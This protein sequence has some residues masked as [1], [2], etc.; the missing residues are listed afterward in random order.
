MYTL[1][2]EGMQSITDQEVAQ[3]TTRLLPSLEDIPAEFLDMTWANPWYARNA[4]NRLAEALYYGEPE[5]EF[6]VSV[7]EGWP[8][9]EYTIEALHR[10]IMAHV[11]SFD[12]PLYQKIAG[13][14]YM[15]SQ[16]LTL[17][18]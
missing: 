11:N 15:I 5:P 9:D 18:E 12:P 6:A 13:V 4:Y 14:G 3:G 16:V 1:T 10:T 7:N 2:L 17:T 8:G